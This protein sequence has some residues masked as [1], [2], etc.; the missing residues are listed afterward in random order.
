MNKYVA[1]VALCCVGLSGC[2]ALVPTFPTT[3]EAV[4]SAP[5]AQRDLAIQRWRTQWDSRVLFVHSP[6]LPM[7]DVRIIFDAGSARDGDAP[8]LASLTSALIGEGAAGLD[9]N[10]IARGFEDLGVAFSSSSYRDMAVAEM[11]VLSD[12]D[13]L[14]PALDLFVKVIGKPTFPEDSLVRLRNQTLTALQQ[15]KQVPG[16]QLS[17][18]FWATLYGD[19]PYGH[20]SEGTEQSLPEISRD[21][22]ED[23]HRRHYNA[24]NAVIA[25]TGDVT[26]DE[27]RGLANIISFALGDGMMAPPLM[28]AEPLPAR[29]VEHLPFES[30]QTVIM[31]GN[32][33]IWRGHPDYV[34][35]YVGNHI[36]G[37]GGFGSILTDQV[38]EE[39]GFVYGIGSGFSPMAAAGPFVIRFQTGVDNA[40]EALALTLSLLD[41]FVRDGPTP[42]QV[43]DAVA[44]IVGSFAL[45]TAEND[46]I[47]GQLGAMGFYGL[48]TDYLSW[49]EAEVR[50]VTPDTI[51]AA[52]RRHVNPATL[53]VLSIGP[54]AP[55]V[56]VTD[57]LPAKPAPASAD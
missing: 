50:K 55:Q 9:V 29:V 5:P 27:A 6:S 25:I 20:P 46:D 2:S 57:A 22:V 31:L 34:N 41:D 14:E 30:R 7:V 38:R 36:L 26:A 3:L 1:V 17:D 49:F 10:D 52:F 47:V 4:A 48:P 43:D 18:R 39:K 37:G 8:G 21:D 51:R 44:N 45:G 28:R 15:Q 11:R 32:Q 54:Q 42:A 35:L 24:A 23:F 56:P 16:P 40:D 13:Y 33:A 19:H 12:R 53:S